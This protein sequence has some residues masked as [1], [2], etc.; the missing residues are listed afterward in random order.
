MWWSST[1]RLNLKAPVQF[2]FMPSWWHRHYGIDFG[3]RLFVDVEH[4]AK[5]HGEM[6]RLAFDRF[7]ELGIGEQNSQPVHGLDDLGN[8]TIAAV[9]GADVEFYKDNYPMAHPL[10]EDRIENLTVPADIT[11]VYPIDEIIRQSEYLRTKHN[12]DVK[13]GWN[14]QGVQNT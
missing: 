2:N 13:P 8:S 9:M 3:E 10:S 14:C 1:S 5:T 12:V 4:R 7:G 11:S 6:N